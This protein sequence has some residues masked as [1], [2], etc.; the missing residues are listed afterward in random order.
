MLDYGE[1]EQALEKMQPRQRLYKIVKAEVKKR[2]HW[3]QLP[4]NKGNPENFTK[5]KKKLAP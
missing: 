5:N 4:R 1:I 3:K 2:G